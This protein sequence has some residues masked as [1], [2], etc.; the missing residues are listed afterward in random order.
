MAS[1]RHHR[2][3][4]DR[5]SVVPHRLDSDTKRPGTGSPRLEHLEHRPVE[6]AAV[7][8]LV[9]DVVP[10]AV[11]DAEA[12]GEVP[13]GPAEAGLLDLFER[14]VHPGEDEPVRRHVMQPNSPTITP[15]PLASKSFQGLI[16][17]R[18]IVS[19]VMYLSSFVLSGQIGSGQLSSQLAHDAL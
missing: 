8:G 3:F 6:L 14:V 16:T 7:P 10:A 18:A 5:S 2:T 1:E 13:Q 15:T 19:R 11:A 17:S 4:A 12:P 9:G